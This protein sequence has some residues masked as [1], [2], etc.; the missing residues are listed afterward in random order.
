MEILFRI[1]S[2]LAEE[3]ILGRACRVIGNLSQDFASGKEFLGLGVMPWLLKTL[4]EAK[5]AKV[6]RL[7]N[8]TSITAYRANQEPGLSSKIA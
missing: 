1:I 8:L 5:T 4:K 3:K 6:I 2:T 7:S